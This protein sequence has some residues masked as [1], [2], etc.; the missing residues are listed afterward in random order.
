MTLG[1][2]DFKYYEPWKSKEFQNADIERGA[3]VYK[4]YCVQC[5][6]KKGGGD[7]PGAKGLDPKPAAHE[8]LPLSE[9]PDD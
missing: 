1:A 7:G 3:K 6:G 5:H 9:Y 8:E 2:K 4:E